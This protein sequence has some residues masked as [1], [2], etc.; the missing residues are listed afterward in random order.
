[1]TNLMALGVLSGRIFLEGIGDASHP[2]KSGIPGIPMLARQSN[3]YFF[4][5]LFCCSVRWLVR[6]TKNSKSELIE[7][8]THNCFN[9][10]EGKVLAGGIDSHD[11]LLDAQQPPLRV[12][13]RTA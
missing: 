2:T 12:K 5:P 9:I 6:H 8:N 3:E 10:P 13:N 1:M 4:L 11:G 7:W